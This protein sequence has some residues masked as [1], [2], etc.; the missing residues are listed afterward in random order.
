M[1]DRKENKMNTNVCPQH[2]EILACIHKVLSCGHDEYDDNIEIN[3]CVIC[4]RR[5]QDINGEKVE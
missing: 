2:G 3:W 1:F 5:L 4:G